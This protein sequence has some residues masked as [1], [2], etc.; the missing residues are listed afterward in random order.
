MPRS[1]G[2]STTT[3]LLTAAG[4]KETKRAV[5]DVATEVSTQG[6]PSGRSA[7]GHDHLG[8]EG[9]LGS[10]AV[11]GSVATGRAM[12]EAGPHPATGGDGS[13]PALANIVVA[14]PGPVEA[15]PPTALLLRPELRG[16]SSPF[17]S[18]RVGYGQRRTVFS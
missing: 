11:S 18:I 3:G 16:R 7:D 4:C 1:G 14:I 9:R 12:V 2:S 5:D 15:R 17:E 13:L 6:S 8:A 10:E